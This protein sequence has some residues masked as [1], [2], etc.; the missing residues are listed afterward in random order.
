MEQERELREFLLRAT[1][2]LDLN[3]S[4]TQL[5]QFLLHLSLLT[6]WNK[7]T[8]LTSI[9]DPYE[10][11]T[12]HFVDSL[13]ALVAVDF[14]LHCT[15][16]DVGT[17]GGFPGIPLKIARNDLQMVLIEPILKK[18]S[19]LRSVVGSLKL[20]NVS[21]FPGT[22]QEFGEQDDQY[23]HSDFVVIRALKFSEIVEQTWKLLKPSGCV[24][25]YRTEAADSRPSDKRFNLLSETNFALPL[26]YGSRV[27]T[28]MSKASSIRA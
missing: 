5:N 26:N 20:D 23:Q 1:S 19:F 22:L 21:I 8:N 14:P 11:I 4:A 10:V 25:L 17:G 27:I 15:V 3:L 7:T 28:V 13:T 24:V 2:S 9:T 6:Q 12:K 16:V 18:C